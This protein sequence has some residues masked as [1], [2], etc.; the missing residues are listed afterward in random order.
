VIVTK[1]WTVMKTSSNSTIPDARTF[2]H[3]MP[4]NLILFDLHGLLATIPK[5]APHERRSRWLPSSG[6]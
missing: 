1:T 3:L 2:V 4:Y 6:Y 5:S